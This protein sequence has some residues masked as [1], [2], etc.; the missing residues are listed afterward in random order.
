MERRQ[1]RQGG[2]IGRLFQALS[3]IALSVGS[4]WW[5]LLVIGLALVAT[6][7]FWW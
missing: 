7:W 4:E 5:V 2:V 6:A 3:E 1:P